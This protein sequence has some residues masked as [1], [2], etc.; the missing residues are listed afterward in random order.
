MRALTTYLCF[1]SWGQFGPQ[2]QR[3]QQKFSD[4][5]RAGIGLPSV[6]GGLRRQIFLGGD[7]FI[8]R[9]QAEIAADQPLDEVPRLQR[10]PAAKPLASYRKEHGGNPHLGMAL[11]YLSGDYTMKAV[12]EE[13]GVHY[14]TV[15]RA[16]KEFESRRTR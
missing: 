5:V 1:D 12:A 15:S 6:W 11:A 9:L 13:F 8:A 7:K 4:F 2:R 10:R 14:T 16:V 3:A